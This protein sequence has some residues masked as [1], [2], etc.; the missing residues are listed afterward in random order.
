M[1]QNG[2]KS[3]PEP[4]KFLKTGQNT[5]TRPCCR[6]NN[7]FWRPPTPPMTHTCLDSPRRGLSKSI[8]RSYPYLSPRRSYWSKTGKDVPKTS[9]LGSSESR[10]GPPSPRYRYF[11]APG[12]CG[13][14]DWIQHPP[15]RGIPC[16][17][18]LGPTFVDPKASG[19]G[20]GEGVRVCWRT[21][22]LT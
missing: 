21:V 1:T 19:A 7:F 22:T 6:L 17:Q 2:L 15:N 13:G 12:G 16:C 20:P 14:W 11:T 8:F 18:P 5:L 10:L 3:C 4:S 9:F